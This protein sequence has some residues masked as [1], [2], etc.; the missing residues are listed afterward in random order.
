MSD[1]GMPPDEATRPESGALTAPEGTPVA[2]DITRDIHARDTWL[3]LL[4]GPVVWF[5]HFMVVYLVAEAGCTGSGPGLGV[6]DPP[7]PATVT[8]VATIV[9]VV[10]CLVLAAWGLRRSRHGVPAGDADDEPAA[11]ERHRSL[12][13]VGVVLALLSAVAVLFVGVPALVFTGC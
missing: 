12:A 8:I 10:A 1:D 3:V 9:A 13:F 11:H 2:V 7:V 5:G 4:G 6:F